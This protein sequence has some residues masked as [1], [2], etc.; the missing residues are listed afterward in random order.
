MLT[1]RNIMLGAACAAIATPAPAPAPAAEASARAF[2]TAIYDAYKGKNG[3]GISLDSE[4]NVRRY[5][6]PSLAAL[7]RKDQK[8]AARRDDVGALDIDP[9]VDAQDWD[10][11]AFDIAASDAAPGKA[12]ATVS[13]SNRD[14][15]TT[16]VLD[17]VKIKNDWKI[18]NITWKRDGE[19]NTLRGLFAP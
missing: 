10:I 5:F 2:V 6:E 9:F 13:F 15:P 17:L 3:N 4:T 1:R 14:K 16:V 18:S 7:I 12:S 8:D 19:T 11:A